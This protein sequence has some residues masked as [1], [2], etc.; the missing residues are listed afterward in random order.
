MLSSLNINP[1]ILMDTLSMF[2]FLLTELTLLFLLISFA[3]GWLQKN[4][5]NEHGCVIMKN[6][7]R[8]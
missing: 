8:Q 3:V 7:G 6:K 5:A 1:T 4:E 2:S